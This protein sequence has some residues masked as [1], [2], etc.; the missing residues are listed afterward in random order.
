MDWKLPMVLITDA[1]GNALGGCLMQK[2][3][4]H[5][6]PLRFMSRTLDKFE[7]AQENREREM[8]AGLYCMMKCNSLLSHHVFTWCTDHANIQYVMTAKSENQRVARLA[9]WLSGYMYNLQHMAGDHILMR[10]AD[11]LSR[12]MIDTGEDR[13]IFVPFEDDVVQHQLLAAMKEIWSKSPASYSMCKDTEAKMTRN[14]VE[15][16]PKHSM[17]A[18]IDN[19]DLGGTV[20]FD[21]IAYDP[22][23]YLC[24]NVESV[25]YGSKPSYNS[26]DIYS[27]AGE[28]IFGSTS[29]GFKVIG[30]VESLPDI[31]PLLARRFEDL[32]FYDS[33]VPLAN[34][35]LQEK[36]QLPY[37]SFVNSK[38]S[39][40]AKNAAMSVPSAEC[41]RLEATL[42]LVRAL[43]KVQGAYKV[44]VV[45]LWF[46]NSRR[47]QALKSFVSVITRMGYT[48]STTNVSTG[49]YGDGVNS[50]IKLTVLSLGM[51]P[52]VQPPDVVTTIADILG[53]ND[54]VP[55]LVRHMEDPQVVRFADKGI[56]Y[57]FD[58]NLYRE[59]NG[60][61]QP[62]IINKDTK[63]YPKEGNA[64]PPSNSTFI[65][66]LTRGPESTRNFDDWEG[67]KLTAEES[68]KLYGLN[69]QYEVLTLFK[70][71][72]TA[73]ILR[74]TVPAKTV[75]FHC[76]AA[77]TFLQSN[78]EF[79]THVAAVTEIVSKVGGRFPWNSDCETT[80]LENL[81]PSGIGDDKTVVDYDLIVAGTDVISELHYEKRM[82]VLPIKKRPSK[83]R[84]IKDYSKDQSP[85][86]RG[87]GWRKANAETLRLRKE[88]SEAFKNNK[89]QQVV[90]YEYFC[91]T[92]VLTAAINKICPKWV[93]ITVDIVDRTLSGL[94]P[95]LMV[96]IERLTPEA[97]HKQFLKH[98][99]PSYI[100]FAPECGP[101]SKQHV[102]G[103][104]YD[105]HT[106]APRSS[107]A[108]RA[109][110]QVAQCMMILTV[111]KKFNPEVLFT[112]ENPDYIKFKI[113]PG[114]KEY[115][116]AGDYDCI[117]LSDYDANFTMK[118][119]V[120]V[121]NV[122]TWEPIKKGSGNLTNKGKVFGGLSL[123]ERM[124]YPRSLCD[125][126]ITA[127]ACALGSNAAESFAPVMTKSATL[128]LM[129]A[130]MLSQKDPSTSHA[131]KKPKV[132]KGVTFSVKQ[133]ESDT[134]PNDSGDPSDKNDEEGT[135]L[136]TEESVV[137]RED[138]GRFFIARSE[139]I[140]AQDNDDLLS[141]CK[142]LATL[143]HKQCA[144]EI[145]SNSKNDSTLS[146]ELDG[147]IAAVQEEYTSNLRKLKVVVSRYNS[148]NGKS[149]KSVQGNAQHMFM[150]ENDVMVYATA[151]GQYPVPVITPKLG[152]RII[153]VAHDA[154]TSVHIGDRKMMHWIR[155]RYW[156]FGMSSE[157]SR[158]TK[159]CLLCQKMKFAASPGYG[160]MQMRVYDRP[161][162]CICIDIVVLNH[163]S[164]A[165]TRYLFTILDCFSH[166]VDAQTMKEMKADDCARCLLKWCE[167]NGVPEEVRSDGGLNL[168]PSE[169]FKSL[170]KLFGIGKLTNHPYAPQSNTVERFHRWLGASLRILYYERDLDV[171]E[172]LPYVLWI[173]RAT[174]NRVTG[175]TPFMLHLGREVRFPLDVFE[176][177][178]I[179]NTPNE[180]T[181]HMQE[182]MRT[183]WTQARVAQSVAQ[184]ESAHYY[185]LKH[186]VIRDYTVNAKVFKRKLPRFQG[187]VSTHMLPHCT[188][189][190][191]ILKVSTKG[192]QLKHCVT[193]G[194]SNSTL[195]H[196]RPAYYRTDDDQFDESGQ[197]SFAGGQLVVVRLT[198]VPKNDVRKW[199]VARLM[200]TT[201]D[202]DAWE[203]QWYNTP[204]KSGPM[205]DKRY[206]SSW[207]VPG[208]Q[209]EK[210]V[211][212]GKQESGWLPVS[213]RVYK[214]RFLTP[215]FKLTKG[216]RLPDNI[217]SI[218]RAKFGNKQEKLTV[219]MNGK[220]QISPAQVVDE[221]EDGS[222]PWMMIN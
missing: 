82:N 183:V 161:G 169:I 3:G 35:I 2:S 48:L 5:Y 205:L 214:G 69:K 127:V 118:P 61:P 198:S 196:L 8:R 188:G 136:S 210:L 120:W 100:H 40:V 56:G 152:R 99:T 93:T 157:I 59:Q 126:V 140:A 71:S 174:E 37:V 30:A 1:S 22:T 166:Y 15:V 171:D 102:R 21:A 203:I 176:N 36:V 158:H 74:K 26:L 190:Y 222:H 201:A 184:E 7:K 107:K 221:L 18:I 65:S 80:V 88:A 179:Q 38:I 12:L 125:E 172:S 211:L 128:K 20:C 192:A 27:L 34:A 31:I 135:S 165:G 78:S 52:V 91:G 47:H 109:D 72:V 94:A 42:S 57:L 62:L 138:D 134:E 49:R 163:A 195:R 130:F 55:T 121:H 76:F 159:T 25:R 154:L 168:N 181:D 132:Q 209:G 14:S 96:D 87:V 217:K 204:D 220:G 54:H 45:F 23:S 115:I 202:Q 13:D 9:L 124:T 43:N 164:P 58:V 11:A 29:A 53:D 90:C 173:Y 84:L 108:K 150:N 131:S 133:V 212:F 50:Q 148:A 41:D 68:C 197:T 33:V 114:V 186:G 160:F 79:K 24:S 142:V 147:Q 167:Y 105:P 123:T 177:E 156:W 63:Y 4:Q 206:M 137:E 67:R 32:A 117:N 85:R 113:L 193:G 92:A 110:F 185:N 155:L 81:I 180:F 216:Q 75:R 208:K 97:V 162:R 149:Y 145:Q 70:D 199:Q 89:Y 101:R 139:I 17:L 44:P 129:E 60:A 182:M 213:W 10:I 143:K 39:N 73:N 51:F 175:F 122:C 194:I 106:W 112:L 141:A 218:L 16:G 146:K 116:T 170:Y 215:S 6:R 98:G 64:K 178:V 103:L 187:E 83:N 189:P 200:H 153:G 119:S 46:L 28:G 19:T 95:T 86:P 104:H 77:L 144:L 191:R 207:E 111:A 219:I 151:N 66:V